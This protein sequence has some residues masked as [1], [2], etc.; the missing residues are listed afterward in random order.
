MKINIHSEYESDAL[1]YNHC[2][3]SNQSSGDHSRHYHDVTEILFVKS[4]DIRYEVGGRIYE[5][6]KNSLI[7]SRPNVIHNICVEGAEAYERYDMLF[8][9]KSLPCELSERI[10]QELDVISFDGNKTV[11][12]AFERMDAYCKR[13]EGEDLERVLFGIIFEV[14]INVVLD[15]K[16]TEPRK[17]LDPIVENA[18]KYIDENLCLVGGVEEICRELFISR[19]HLHHLFSS[20]LDTSP[21]KY[22][23]ERRLD[24]ARQAL[25]SGGKAT[26]IYAEYGFGDYSSFFRA[27][28]NR[29]GFSPAETPK[30]ESLRITFSDMIKGNIS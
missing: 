5:V 30:N 19:S 15:A 27:Y 17:R 23:S 29:F 22:I 3:K 11:T 4:G 21:K 26:E 13:L 12:D 8:E 1:Y 9:A 18:L 10:P 7:I 25:A 6:G 2:T 24:R 28:K 16:P 14:L 20:E